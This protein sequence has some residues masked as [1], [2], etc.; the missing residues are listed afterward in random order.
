MKMVKSLECK[1]YK[2]WLSWA[3]FQPRV[4][5]AEERPHG[6]LQVLIG[7][8]GSVLTQGNSMEQCEGG[9]N[10]VLGKGSSPEGGSGTSTGTPGQWAWTAPQNQVRKCW[11][12]KERFHSCVQ[13]SYHYLPLC[14]SYTNNP[15]HTCGSRHFS[16]PFTFNCFKTKHA[17]QGCMISLMYSSSVWEKT[18]TVLWCMAVTRLL[19]IIAEFLCLYK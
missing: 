8:R 3:S 11:S 1:L 14:S 16:L 4:E 19:R 9:S 2:E 17:T 7:S 15:V 10:W 13:L 18:G 12:Q 5:E 6:G